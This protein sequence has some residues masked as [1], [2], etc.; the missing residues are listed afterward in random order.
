MKIQKIVC[1]RCGKEIINNPVG[2]L[3]HIVDRETGI[4]T[5][6]TAIQGW[7]EK[8]QDYDFCE[9]C[10]EK[11][12]QFAKKKTE[13]FEKNA[14][15]HLKEHTEEELADIEKVIKDKPLTTI[16]AAEPKEPTV[17]SVTEEPKPMVT[18]TEKPNKKPTVEELI[19]QG[20]PKKEVVEITGCK[21]QTYSQVKYLLK[22]KG[23]LP[24]QQKPDKTEQH[25]SDKLKKHE[26]DEFKQQESD[27]STKEVKTYQCSKVGHKCIYKSG[28]GQN[29]T[30]DYIGIAGHRR[31]CPPEQCDKY[32]PL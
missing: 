26:S 23:L 19:L 1:D 29:R 5:F 20:V 18:D 27:E 2:I 14:V 6:G 21:S 22:K 7:D 32:K 24:Q 16:M 10:A 4:V 31:G 17:K 25:E 28:N 30:C 11:I 3:P 9:E 8:L 12:I 15:I 13:E